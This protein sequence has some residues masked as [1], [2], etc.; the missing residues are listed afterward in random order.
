MPDEHVRWVKTRQRERCGTK[1]LD[2]FG[3]EEGAHCKGVNDHHHLIQ[4]RPIQV[5][6]FRFH[7]LGSASSGSYLFR[8]NL[9]QV[10][11]D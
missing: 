7:D 1:N 6:R 10:P 5:S 8:F 4:V 3:A 9:I 11:E 2:R